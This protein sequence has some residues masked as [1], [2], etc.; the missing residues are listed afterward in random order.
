MVKSRIPPPFLSSYSDEPEGT[1]GAVAINSMR[2]NAVWGDVPPAYEDDNFGL[3]DGTF[4]LAIVVQPNNLNE[5]QS[6]RV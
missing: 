1:K 4:D 2:S 3:V 6:L 5:Q